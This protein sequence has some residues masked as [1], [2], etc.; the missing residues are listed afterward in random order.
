M[1]LVGAIFENLL[2]FLPITVVEEHELGVYLRWGKYKKTVGPGGYRT[3]WPAEK[4]IV[5]NAQAQD[6]PILDVDMVLGDDRVWVIDAAIAYTIENA[7]RYMLTTREP[8]ELLTT[9]AKSQILSYKG[10]NRIVDNTIEVEDEIYGVLDTAAEQWGIA[11]LRFKFVTMA[12][13]KV[14]V[15][16]GGKSPHLLPAYDD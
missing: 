16:R 15:I 3:V 8:D 2:E 12:P 11:V 13:C 7:Y 1:S 9:L 6:L 5:V 4:I 14:F 10:D